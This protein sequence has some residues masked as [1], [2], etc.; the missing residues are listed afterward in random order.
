MI[1]YALSGS[2]RSS[3]QMDVLGLLK[4]TYAES[5]K[6]T[7]K[8]HLKAY[9]SFCSVL[10]VPLVP[11]DPRLVALYA[12]LLSRTLRYN[13]IVGYLNIISILHK[14]FDLKSPLDSFLVKCVMKGIK[15][16]IGHEPSIKL[17][18][19]PEILY[20]ML[21]ILD[22]NKVED[23]CIWMT[24][25]IM[26]F[27]LLRKSNVVGVHKVLRQDCHFTDNSVELTIRS[28]KTRNRHLDIPR[29]M[30]LP[31]FKGHCLCPVAA[32]VNYIGKT[33]DLPKNAPL[34]SVPSV[35]KKCK[36]VPL[37]YKSIVTVIRKSVPVGQEGSFSTHS[38]RRGGASYMFK[39]GL[40]TDTIRLLGDWRS[41][42]YQRYIVPDSAVLS[43]R[44]ISM[45]QQSLP[46]RT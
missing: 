17:P 29:V 37:N 6:A 45:M 31:R 28:S 35:G 3:L 11:A 34:C 1:L 41:E 21:E 23:A 18:I 44:A 33:P 2:L 9:S 27:G 16:T 12:A 32:L 8:C 30:S 13:S 22:M 15:N 26:F 25:L 46:E 7:Y 43:F 5:T 38:F 36:F 10:G 40:S 42:A 4:S 24:S 39:I 14:S 19:T 20:K